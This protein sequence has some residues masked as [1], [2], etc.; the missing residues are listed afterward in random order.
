MTIFL[1][2]SPGGACFQDGEEIVCDLDSRNEFTRLL[3]ERW[4]REMKC[5]MI[6][7]DPD[8]VETNDRMKN[9]FAEALPK[10][11]FEIAKID[12][13][14]RRNQT[15]MKEKLFTYDVIILCG[16]HVPTQNAFFRE[17]GLRNLIQKFGGIVIGISAGTM[18][19]AELVYAIPELPQEATSVGYQR[20]LLGLGL[21]DIMVIPHYQYLRG[22]KLDG[23]SVIGDIACKDSEGRQF[24]A[25]PDGSY[26]LI[27][28]GQTFVY[29]EAYLIQNG[30]ITKICEENEALNISNGEDIAKLALLKRCRQ[31]ESF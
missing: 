3:A 31:S 22:E 28:H 27:E 5:L 29:G 6:S 12:I 19:S 1:T 10:S 7:S 24:L 11:G 20:F 21:T 9:I 4:K 26:L 16:G 14:D 18:N 30:E 15:I 8:G 2:S 23:L 13:W 25:L 17:I